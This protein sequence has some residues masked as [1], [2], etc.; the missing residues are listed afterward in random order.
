MPDVVTQVQCSGHSHTVIKQEDANTCGAKA[1]MAAIIEMGK[2]AGI[3]ADSILRGGVGIRKGGWSGSELCTAFE[4]TS[5]A[6]FKSAYRL[7]NIGSGAAFGA[8]LRNGDL[9]QSP[10][11]A[12]GRAQKNGVKAGGHWMAIVRRNRRFGRT[13][14][15]CVLCSASGEVQNVVISKDTGIGQ[16]SFVDHKQQRWTVQI[17]GGYR[18]VNP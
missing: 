13:S 17:G 7:V 3:T 18:I 15:F 2:G 14:S 16:F 9:Q 11:I 12:H 10:V 1:L 5:D 8:E 4:L 6:H